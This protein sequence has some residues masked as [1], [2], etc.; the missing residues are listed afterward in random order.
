MRNISVFDFDGT[1]TTKD[2]LLEFIKFACG[3]RAFYIGFFLHSPLL[4]LMKLGLYPNWKAKERVYSWFF[5]GMKYE[6][7]AEMGRN[8]SSCISSF[9][10][11]KTTVILQKHTHQQDDVYVITASV[12]EWVRPYCMQLGVKEVLGT[13]VEIQNGVLTGRFA[14]R[15]CNGKEKVVR[16]LEVEPNRKSYFLVAYGDS[17]GDK[18]LLDFSDKGILIKYL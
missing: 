17:R 3:R 6:T 11:S 2:T 14:S 15:N 18:E 16:L 1:L 9:A 8:F 13:K 10:N 12:E 7:F 5:K 4:V